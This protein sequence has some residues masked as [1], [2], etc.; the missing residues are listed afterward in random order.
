MQEYVGNE[1]ELGPSKPNGTWRIYTYIKIEGKILKKVAIKSNLDVVLRDQFKREGPCKL[2]VIIWLF[3]P[4]IV[5]IT[6]DDG[7][8]FRQSLA[9]LYGY[10]GACLLFILFSLLHIDTAF[11]KFFFFLSFVCVLPS[12]LLI[13]K[14]RKVS[15]DH[16]Y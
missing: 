9:L 13:R 1:L 15:A 2:W 3:R 11:G 14:I 5:A 8:T 7:Q 12:F 16:S 10:S 4:L 6:Q